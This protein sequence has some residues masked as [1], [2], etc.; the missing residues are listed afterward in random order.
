MNYE[1][2]IRDKNMKRAKCDELR[3][4]GDVSQGLHKSED[5]LLSGTRVLA[6][7]SWGPLL[8]WWR[9]LL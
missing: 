7:D 8:N 6:T 2:N 3:W 4:R 9:W 1:Y 5:A